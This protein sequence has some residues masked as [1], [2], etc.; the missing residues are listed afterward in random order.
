[1]FQFLFIIRTLAC[2][3]RF[4][5]SLRSI[6]VDRRI[7]ELVPMELQNAKL[8]LVRSIQHT[9]YASELELLAKG[10]SLSFKHILSPLHPFLDDQG[11]MR[12]GGRLQNSALPY[13]QKHPLILP[14]NHV[15]TEMFV[16]EA[17]MRNLHAGPSFLT[18]TI[19]QQ[20]WI[21][22]CQTVV[23]KVVQGGARCPRCVRLKGKTAKQLMGNLPP[24]RVRASRVF[25]HVGVDYAGP[26]K[27]KASCVRGVKVTKGYIVVFVC[28]STRAVHLEVACDLSTNTFINVLKRFVSRRGY[29]NE[30]W[31]DN[32]TN[33]VGADRVLQE[34]VEKIKSHSKEEA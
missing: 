13:D 21:V 22:G 11:T 12:V 6:A 33:F 14:Q 30:I 17:H 25:S 34:F 18:A 1:M 26:I 4:I 28:L 10:K 5:N 27:L 23:R 9:A 24:V 8:Q 31:S 2:V 15:A 7:G 32:G 19:Y 16:R 29:P 20:Y 3:N